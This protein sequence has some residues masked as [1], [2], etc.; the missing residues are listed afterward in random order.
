MSA[1]YVHKVIKKFKLRS[2]K[3]IK[4][5]NRNDEVDRRAKTRARKLLTSELKNFTGCILMDDETY[6]K[7]DFKQIP[8]VQF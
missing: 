1:S 3:V 8:G 2:F 6:V 7:C 4:V 5:P